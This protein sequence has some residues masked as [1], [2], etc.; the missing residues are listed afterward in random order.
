MGGCYQLFTI[1]VT[2][3]SPGPSW[4]LTL[5]KLYARLHPSV[6]TKHP[7]WDNQLEIQE[8]GQYKDMHVWLCVTVSAEWPGC[9]QPSVCPPP[10]QTG[11]FSE[12]VRRISTN[13]CEYGTKPPYLQAISFFFFFFCFLSCVLSFYFRGAGEAFQMGVKIPTHYPCTWHCKWRRRRESK[14]RGQEPA[15]LSKMAA[16]Q[17]ESTGT[18]RGI[19]STKQPRSAIQT[20]T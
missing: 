8:G 20:G 4:I 5:Y 3:R 13:F 12:T 17:F 19:S 10:Q 2:H 18:R 14:Q 1:G 11:V 9:R 16:N 7:P 15:L 6:N